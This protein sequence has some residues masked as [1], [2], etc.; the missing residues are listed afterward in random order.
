MHPNFIDALQEELQKTQQ[1]KCQHTAV[2]KSVPSFYFDI[3]KIEP[4]N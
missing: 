4:D 1:I 3:P 2:Q